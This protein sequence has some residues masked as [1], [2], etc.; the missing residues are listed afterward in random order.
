MKSS[1]HVYIGMRLIHVRCCAS[2][3]VCTQQ[4]YRTMQTLMSLKSQK[5]LKYASDCISRSIWRRLYSVICIYAYTHSCSYYIRH[6]HISH[7]YIGARISQETKSIFCV[8][9]FRGSE[10]DVNDISEFSNFRRLCRD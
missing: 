2:V 7:P 10:K 6:F 8:N 9:I 3:R 4:I 1:Y 5:Y